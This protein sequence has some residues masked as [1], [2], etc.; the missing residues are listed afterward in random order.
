MGLEMKWQSENITKMYTPPNV[1]TKIGFVGTL[2][3]GP[4]KNIIIGKCTRYIK[5]DLC[6]RE[7]RDL[8]TDG[9]FART[10]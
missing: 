2:R 10:S 9:I 4:I 7:F 3:G 8:P 6:E 5:Y 1:T